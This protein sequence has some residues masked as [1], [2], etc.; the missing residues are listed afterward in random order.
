M[1]PFLRP[2]GTQPPCHSRHDFSPRRARQPENC[3]KCHLGPD[4]PQKEIY[5][6]SKH[7]VAFRDLKDQMNL[8]AESW[9]LGKDYS[10]APTC[11]TCH[12]SAN[13][14]NAQKVTHDPGE[15]ISWT[16]RPPVSKVMDTDAEHRIV[17]ET[18]PAKRAERIVDSCRAPA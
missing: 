9:V 10:A 2:D 14:R 17:T 8:D 3:A 12:M 13:L 16:N 1:T 15:R 18:D 7:G 5:E 4:H 6:E 11:A